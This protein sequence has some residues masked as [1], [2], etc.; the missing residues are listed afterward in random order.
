MI[1]QLIGLLLPS[2]IGLK[3]YDKLYGEEKDVLRRIE[4]YL[5]NVLYVNLISY[6]IVVYIFK[7]PYFI[8]TNQFTIKYMILSLIILLILPRIEKKIKGNLEVKVRVEKNETE[9]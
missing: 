7:V 1:N 3:V 2:I 6:I 4:R 8:F 9:G 5:I